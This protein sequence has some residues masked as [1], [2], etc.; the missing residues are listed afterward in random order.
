VPRKLR[1]HVSNVAIVVE[2]EPPPGQPYSAYTR[3][4]SPR[5]GAPMRG[6]WRT[7]SRS[8]AARSSGP[9]GAD[10]EKLRQQIRRVVLRELAHHFGISDQRLLELDRY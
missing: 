6:R 5:A 10:A 4:S 9:Y 7:R 3:G 8:S 2:D 1:E